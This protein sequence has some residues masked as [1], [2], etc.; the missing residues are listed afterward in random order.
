M[1]SFEFQPVDGYQT[2][3]YCSRLRL[4]RAD[5]ARIETT[6]LLCTA[7]NRGSPTEVWSF[8]N[9]E[10]AAMICRISGAEAA[11]MEQAKPLAVGGA[12]K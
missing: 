12:L 1:A 6:T 10:P 8:G 3:Q 7:A 5:G 9:Q 4:S 2:E 11:A